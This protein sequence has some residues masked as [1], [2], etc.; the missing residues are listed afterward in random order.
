MEEQTKELETIDVNNPLWDY[1][2]LDFGVIKEKSEKGIFLPESIQNEDIL[3]TTFY[4]TV[5]GRGHNVTDHIQIGDRV[6]IPME[7]FTDPQGTV[8]RPT[9]FGIQLK[10][11]GRMYYLIRQTDCYATVNKQR[12][13]EDS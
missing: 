7:R 12:L 10:E 9:C 13:N 8:V 1:V 3:S 2:K 4:P 6:L 11:N 5:V